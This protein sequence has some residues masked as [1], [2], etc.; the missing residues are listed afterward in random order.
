[1]SCADVKPFHVRPLHLRHRISDE[2]AQYAW[3]PDFGLSESPG[4]MPKYQS[5]SN[6]RQR[7]LPSGKLQWEFRG[8]AVYGAES[9]WVSENEM[10]GTFTPLQLNGFVA[11]WR[12]C[13]TPQSH[14]TATA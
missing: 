14:P 10:L 11:L 5:L 2:F 7:A 6:C 9:E 12:L 13:T 3:G 8:V 4:A 1:V